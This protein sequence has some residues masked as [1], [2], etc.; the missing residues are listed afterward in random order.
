[1]AT[2]TPHPNLPELATVLTESSGRTRVAQ[3]Y[4]EALARSATVAGQADLVGDELATVVKSVL[5]GHPAVNEFLASAAINKKAKLPILAAAFENDTSETFRKFLGVLNQNRRLDLLPS[6]AQ[7]YQKLQDAANN[8]VQVVVKSA[9]ELSAE[10]IEQLR[11]TLAK[12]LGKTPTLAVSTDPDILGGLVVQVGD[13]VYDSSVRT[14]LDDLRT[15][16]LS[17]ANHG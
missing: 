10:Q 13:T 12:K 15:H 17:S 1:M 9:V 8:R 14:R 2:A 16:L 7:A 4:A 6:I 11:G 3:V 5:G